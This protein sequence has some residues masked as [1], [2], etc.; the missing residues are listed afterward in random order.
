MR[1][2]SLFVGSKS[3]HTKEPPKIRSLWSIRTA[4]L[5]NLADKNDLDF[6]DQGLKVQSPKGKMCDPQ[7]HLWS[8]CVF[9]RYQIQVLPKGKYHTTHHLI[10]W[11]GLAHF[12]SPQVVLVGR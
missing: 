6:L 7:S 1:V 10:T 4:G 11:F 2:S 5:R 12:H 3:C 8:Q 9:P